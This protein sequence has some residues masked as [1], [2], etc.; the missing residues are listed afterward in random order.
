LKNKQK[1]SSSGGGAAGAGKSSKDESEPVGIVLAKQ[2]LEMKDDYPAVL[3]IS[4]I[5]IEISSSVATM[6]KAYL[7][8]SLQIHPDKLE[9]TF[10]DATKAF[11]C[12]VNAYERMS[13]PEMF[14]E[15]DEEEKKKQTKIMRSNEGCHRH[16]LFCPRCKAEW[17]TPDTGVEPYDYNFMMMGNIQFHI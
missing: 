9:K 10:P 14:M 2:I 1:S 6:R 16:R 5:N 12:L 3:S 4:G 11:Q 15:E 17:G 7:K 13:Q 8:L